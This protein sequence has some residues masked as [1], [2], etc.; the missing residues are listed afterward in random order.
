MSH[1]LGAVLA[2]G[3]AH[4]LTNV[5]ALE[6]GCSMENACG[7]LEA[8]GPVLRRRGERGPDRVAGLGGEQF[9]VDEKRCH[10]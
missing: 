7:G 4:E 8:G 10:R 9:A 1:L 5:A 6:A 2:P 3:K